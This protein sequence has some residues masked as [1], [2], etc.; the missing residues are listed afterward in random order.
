M[1]GSNPRAHLPPFEIVAL[2]ASAG[3]LPALLQILSSLPADFPAPIV[4]V[5]HTDPRRRSFLAEILGRHTGLRVRPADE[6]DR[7]EHGT[8][9]VAPPDYHLLVEAGGTLR[10]VH[11]DRVQF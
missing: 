5:Q 3:G 9:Y 11:G 7:L 8:A 2:A 10:L 4:L 1:I 6:G